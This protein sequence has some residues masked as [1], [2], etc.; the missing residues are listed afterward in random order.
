MHSSLIAIGHMLTKIIII[1][2]KKRRGL[3]QASLFFRGDYMEMTWKEYSLDK[4]NI[5]YWLKWGGLVHSQILLNKDYSML[6][7]IQYEAYKKVDECIL[8][9]LPRLPNG[10]VYWLDNQHI[11]KK[12]KYYLCVYW[13]PFYSK[14]DLITN[15][16]DNKTIYFEKAREGFLKVVIMIFN[17]LFKLTPCQILQHGALLNYLES[18]I[19][20]QPAVIPMPDT[21]LYLDALLTQDAGIIFEKNNIYIENNQF[22][23][24]SLD[25]YRDDDKKRLANMLKEKN[26][27]YRHVQRLLLF[28]EKSAEREKKRYMQLWCSGRM[29]IRRMISEGIAGNLNGYYMNV[30]IV[31]LPEKDFTD[32][33]TW[34]R[35]KLN[36]MEIPYI[37]ED[38]S[39]KEIWWASLPGM[40]EPYVQPPMVGFR[41]L[42]DLLAHSQE[43]Q[44]ED[45][46][47]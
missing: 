41:N 5:S 35:N 17:T 27:T 38:Y 14:G 44:E 43:E 29:S 34:I 28:S 36:S 40:H 19:T 33:V 4:E 16:V 6:S 7:V 46:N 45:R 32:T 30:L 2:L 18:S 9:S 20:I 25:V 12:T 21:P 11:A 31:S 24:I 23:V 3:K 22:A 39:C 26:I 13:N 15:F 8:D 47:V 10:W 37:V 1:V 42:G